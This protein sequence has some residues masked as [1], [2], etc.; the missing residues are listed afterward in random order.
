LIAVCSRE[1][2]RAVAFAS[3]HGAQVGYGSFEELLSRPDIEVVYVATPHNLHREHVM[4]AARAG[5]HV[6]CEKPLAL[7]TNDSEDMV[8]S[9]RY[10]G[11]HLGVCFQ[12]RYHPVHVEMR[13]LIQAGAVGDLIHVRS[14][15]SRLLPGSWTGW[16]AN[17]SLTGVPSLVG[18]GTLTGLAIHALDVVRY[19]TGEE[20][21]EF[22]AMMD[23]A[24]T[25]GTAENDVAILVRMSGGGFATVHASRRSPRA[26][27][28]VVVDGSKARVGGL[29]TVGTLLEGSLEFVTDAEIR[30]TDYADPD[31]QTGLYSLAI[32]DFSRCV[33]QGATPV[34]TG[35]DG[36]IMTRW[37]EAIVRSAQQGQTVSLRAG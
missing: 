19:I 16:R 2:E 28:D 32:E 36:L 12:N 29:G 30:R 27:N 4:K 10:A 15:Y 18:M 9:C 13:R 26:N 35:E 7:T 37:L 1:R 24:A 11:V 34:A 25:E 8:N 3:R 5:K 21:C 6:L 17:P 33:S 14:Q 22:G 20:G 31:P 23:R